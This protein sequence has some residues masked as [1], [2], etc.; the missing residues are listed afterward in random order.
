MTE[1]ANIHNTLSP[2]QKLPELSSSQL[3][4]SEILANFKMRVRMEISITEVIRVIK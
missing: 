2:G 3:L 4:F 1:A